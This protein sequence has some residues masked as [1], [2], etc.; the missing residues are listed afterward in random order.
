M[1]LT[2][3]VHVIETG[4]R[5]LSAIT[6]ANDRIWMG[7]MGSMSASNVQIQTYSLE[8]EKIGSIELEIEDNIV[9]E[10]VLFHDEKWAICTHQSGMITV[11]NAEDM[12]YK[13]TSPYGFIDNIWGLVK[14]PV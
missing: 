8:Y 14:I 5:G 1:S 11:V 13:T 10:I 3:P 12:S 2:E 4:A 7:F 9:S 6:V